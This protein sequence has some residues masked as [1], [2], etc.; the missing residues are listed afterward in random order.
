MV[1]RGGAGQSRWRTEILRGATKDRVRR[2]PA[3]SQGYPHVAA[4]RVVSGTLGTTALAAIG[5]AGSAA[6]NF[7]RSSKQMPNR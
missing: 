7:R 2:C 5:W 3:S 6:W 4:Y 1:P